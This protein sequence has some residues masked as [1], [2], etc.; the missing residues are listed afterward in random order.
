MDD[1]LPLSI[2]MPG[3]VYGPGDTSGMHTALVDLLRGRLPMTPARTAFCWAHVEDT[4]RGHILAME[5]GRPGETYIIA[6]PRHPF[7]GAFALAASLARVR[8]PMLHPGPRMMRAMAVLMQAAE[9]FLT[10]PPA[11]TPEALRVLAG[12]TYFGSNEKAVRELGFTARPLDEGLAQTL[13]HELR[14]LGRV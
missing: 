14:L 2:V 10:L 3:L 8:A 13:E 6:G 7:E 12:T 11:L 5:K 9:R 1:G 4:A